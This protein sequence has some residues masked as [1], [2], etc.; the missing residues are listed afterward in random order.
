[1]GLRAVRRAGGAQPELPRPYPRLL[2][3]RAYGQGL[4]WPDRDVRPA[5]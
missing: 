5:Q 2:Y 1:M 4:L 3:V